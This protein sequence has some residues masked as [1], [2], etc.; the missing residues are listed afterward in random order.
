MG[1][2]KLHYVVFE[3]CF[4]LE[5]LCWRVDRKPEHFLACF[6]VLQVVLLHS[7]SHVYRSLLILL[8]KFFVALDSLNQ[9]LC[10]SIS[11]RSLILLQLLVNLVNLVILASC[12][13]IFVFN[14]TKTVQFRISEPFFKFLSLLIKLK[15]LF[16]P[17]SK[18]DISVFCV[19][20]KS[21]FEDVATIFQ[22]CSFGSA[23]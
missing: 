2:F 9:S 12:R 8:Q 19:I 17:L 7:A 14:R 21:F 13:Q 22:T 3:S 10:V 6:L 11:N 20:G 5:F 23:W 18:I 16:W 1:F 15:Q 4:W